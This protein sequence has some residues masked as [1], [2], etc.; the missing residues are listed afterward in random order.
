MKYVELTKK[1]Q[2]EVNALPI[3]YAF[4]RKQFENG[5]KEKLGLEPNETDK[6]YKLGNTGGF[7]KKTDAPLLKEVFD[8]HALE[9][10]EAMKDDEFVLDMFEYEMRNHE[11]QY[12][13]DD[14]E[15]VN[16]CG[17]DIDDFKDER[18]WS[19]Y[20]QAKKHYLE[21]CSKNNWY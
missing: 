8:R 9:L 17:L 4:S 19:L 11:F 18:L 5:M 10:Q 6:I 16:A 14:E 7:Y 21:L 20:K 1:H 12:S 13:L 3:M 15:V 2:K